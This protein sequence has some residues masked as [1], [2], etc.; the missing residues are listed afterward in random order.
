M[1]NSKSNCGCGNASSCRNGERILV[2]NSGCG[3]GGAS[4][5]RCACANTYRPGCNRDG[6]CNR[7][8][9]CGCNRERES[10]CCNERENGCNHDRGCGCRPRP[11]PPKPC[12]EDRC[13]MQ[14]RQCMRNCRLR[15][16]EERHEGCGCAREACGYEEKEY[17]NE[18]Y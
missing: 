14:Y 15:E 3:C 16:D 6:G 1:C 7:D 12:C 13:R 10:G 8:R 18:E 4:R 11:C 9:N 2:N 17:C 5:S